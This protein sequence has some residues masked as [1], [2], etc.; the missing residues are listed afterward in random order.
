MIEIKKKGPEW[1]FSPVFKIQY[2]MK[3]RCKN[4][5]TILLNKNPYGYFENNYQQFSYQNVMRYRK[6]T[7]IPVMGKGLMLNAERVILN[8]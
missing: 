2:P 6:N 5:K 3:N 4:N 7:L 8:A 1:K